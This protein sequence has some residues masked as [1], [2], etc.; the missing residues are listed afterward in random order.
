MGAPGLPGQVAGQRADA[1]RKRQRVAAMLPD[2]AANPSGYGGTGI[3]RAEQDFD[4]SASEFPPALDLLAPALA[5]VGLVAGGIDAFGRRFQTGERLRPPYYGVRVT[6]AL[7]HTQGG[8]CID[9]TTRVLDRA[10][11]P[12]PNLF[13]AG[14]AARGVSGDA[15]WGYLSGNGL[16][17]AGQ[18]RRQRFPC[19]PTLLS[20]PQWAS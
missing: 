19:L 10:G 8:L 1:D 17:S 6:G 13:A 7:F 14:G 12:L 16:L 5:L 3:D 9:A 20:I 15:A 2:G 4:A 11:Q 18:D